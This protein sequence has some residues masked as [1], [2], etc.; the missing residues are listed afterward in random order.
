MDQME[1]R[2]LARESLNQAQ[3]MAKEID[4][5]VTNSL[6]FISGLLAMRVIRK[7]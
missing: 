6:Q 7:G 2:L 4:H 3:L 1:L 5:P